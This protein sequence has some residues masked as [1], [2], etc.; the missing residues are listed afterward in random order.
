MRNNYVVCMLLFLG[1]AFRKS[2]GTEKRGFL[3]IRLQNM[4]YLKKY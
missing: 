2:V 3:C 4:L 1:H